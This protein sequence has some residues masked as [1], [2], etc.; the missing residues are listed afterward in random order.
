MRNFEN[1]GDILSLLVGILGALLKGI[2]AKFNASTIFI[3]CL[4][5]GILT[6]SVIGVIELYYEDMSPKIVI[7]VSFIVGWV[8][9]EITAKLDLL[10]GD[11]YDI[12]IA[13]V[14]NKFTKNDKNEKNNLE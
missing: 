2:K 7:L 6:F 5:A 13:Y 10:I 11:V 3:G 1:F 9:N 8:A 4:V 14:K 12:F